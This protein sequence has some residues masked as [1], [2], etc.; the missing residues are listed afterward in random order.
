MGQASTTDGGEPGPRVAATAADTLAALA[1]YAHLMALRAS[2][3]KQ[4]IIHLDEVLGVRPAGK[5][6][7]IAQISERATLEPSG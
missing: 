1:L 6:V 7:D 5:R 2:G 4:A 3:V